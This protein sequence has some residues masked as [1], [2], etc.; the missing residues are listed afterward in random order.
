MACRPYTQAPAGANEAHGEQIGSHFGNGG[1][2]NTLNKLHSVKKMTYFEKHSART[3][4]GS[5]KKIFRAHGIDL[6]S[7]MLLFFRHTTKIFESQPKK[8]VRT[9]M[10]SVRKKNPNRKPKVNMS[11]HEFTGSKPWGQFH[12]KNTNCGFTLFELLVTITI[13][14][15][16]SSILMVAIQSV[17][18]LAK[19]QVCA[20]NLRQIGMGSLQYRVDYQQFPYGDPDAGWPPDISGAMYFTFQDDLDFPK[21]IFHCPASPYVTPAAF[22][23]AN[24]PITDAVARG[25]PFGGRICTDYQYVAQWGVNKSWYTAAWWEVRNSQNDVPAW[26]LAGDYQYHQG[27]S[28]YGNHPKGANT[29]YQ[30]GSV[31]FRT[32]VPLESIDYY[33]FGP[34]MTLAFKR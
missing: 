13:I 4:T 12:G 27:V 18:R 7:S 19:R 15:I 34:L 6:M 28:L 3:R 32:Y 10:A 14:A 11:L 9:V 21:K 20:S 23:Y 29:L 24:A 17:R 31:V 25:I 8:S 26:A 16:L 30:D 2:Q 1:S 22:N 33:S 5:F